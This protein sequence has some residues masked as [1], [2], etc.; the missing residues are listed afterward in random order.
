M[1]VLHST[2]GAL[3]RVFWYTQEEMLVQQCTIVEYNWN[4]WTAV[5][6]QL[7]TTGELERLCSYR[8]VLQA[9]WGGC[10]GT[11]EFV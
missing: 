5:L 11:Y 8:G 10:A 1:L 7:N 9:N 4:T 6:I 3:G 2:V